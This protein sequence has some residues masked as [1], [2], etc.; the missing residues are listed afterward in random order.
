M[1]Q[2]KMQVMYSLWSDTDMKITKFWMYIKQAIIII[3]F[4][5]I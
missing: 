2:K 4:P 1:I 5:D 3:L